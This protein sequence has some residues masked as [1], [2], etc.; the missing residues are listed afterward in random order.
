MYC[1]FTRRKTEEIVFPA[2][3]AGMTAYFCSRYE[4]RKGETGKWGPVISAIIP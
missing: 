2:G 3:E 1:R 4:N